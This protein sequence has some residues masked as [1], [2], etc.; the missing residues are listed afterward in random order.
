MEDA[1]VP[2]PSA[3]YIKLFDMLL[4]C[5]KLPAV[6]IPSPGVWVDGVDG[7]ELGDGPTVFPVPVL[8][9]GPE[10]EGPFLFR[11]LYYTTNKH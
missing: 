5:C 8:L 7:W 2:V 3:P 9:A 6:A 10:D 4:T 1:R 11:L